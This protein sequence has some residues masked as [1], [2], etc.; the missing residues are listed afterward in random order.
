MDIILI[1]FL[2]RFLIIKS[3]VP[4]YITVLT[5]SCSAVSFMVRLLAPSTPGEELDP[6]AACV[7][8]KPIAVTC[9]AVEF[10][11]CFLVPL[12]MRIFCLR[13]H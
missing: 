2:F 4:S 10:S 8:P 13:A 1:T 6:L 3:L 11:F 9:V 5:V 12:G 7:R